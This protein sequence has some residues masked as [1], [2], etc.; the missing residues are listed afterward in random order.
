MDT[1]PLSLL[2]RLKKSP[3]GPAW[4]RMT[5]L[6]EPWLKRQL[7]GHGL[8]PADAEDVVQET[9]MV[10]LREAPTFQH[11]GRRGAF[12]AWLRQVAVNRVREHWRKQSYSPVATGDHRQATFDRLADDNSELSRQW[13]RQHDQYVVGRLLQ[14]ISVDFEEKTWR[15]FRA[16]VIEGKK[17]AEVAASLGVSEG[18]VWTAK[19]HVMK[20][21][22]QVA[23]G[24]ID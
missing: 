1:T 3:D 12:R 11:N 2:E 6:Y 17:A 24:L 9:L 7:I 4:R 22:R 21:L 23:K 20:R 13:D 10:L 8:Q 16:F 14:A 19:S 15:S 5:E 18:A